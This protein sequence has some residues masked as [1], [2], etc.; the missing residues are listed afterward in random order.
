MEEAHLS[1]PCKHNKT[2]HAV[3]G[4]LHGAWNEEHFFG[5]DSLTTPFA[6]FHFSSKFFPK[7][8]LEMYN[9]LFN[10]YLASV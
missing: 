4:N 2:K 3:V 9:L 5:F 8:V 1:Y 6:Q 10:L 7:N